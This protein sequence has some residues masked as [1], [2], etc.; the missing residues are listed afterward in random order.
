[1]TDHAPFAYGWDLL[2]RCRG[3]GFADAHAVAYWSGL[4]GHIGGGVQLVFVASL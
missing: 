3:A 4:Y 1:M 2:D